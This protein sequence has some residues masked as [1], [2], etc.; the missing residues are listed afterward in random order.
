MDEVSD[1][2]SEDCEFES[3]RG[4][5]LFGLQYQ[6]MTDPC[7]LSILIPEPVMFRHSSSIQ[8]YCSRRC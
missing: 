3:L 8:T 1:F 2:E 4:R 5:N 6:I 7:V